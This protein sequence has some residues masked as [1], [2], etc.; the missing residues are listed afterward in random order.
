MPIRPILLLTFSV[1]FCLIPELVSQESRYMSDTIFLRGY[2]EFREDHTIQKHI[3]PSW[4]SGYGTI[5]FGEDKK[6]KRYVLNYYRQ[7]SM[8]YVNATYDD[9]G[10][11]KHIWFKIEEKDKPLIQG[12][13]TKEET[14]RNPIL[15]NY[16]IHSKDSLQ[17]GIVR[18]REKNFPKRILHWNFSDYITV[19]NLLKLWKGETIKPLPF[20]DKVKFRRTKEGDITYITANGVGVREEPNTQSKVR[21]A[22]STGYRFKIEEVM[23]MDSISPWGLHPW[24][25]VRWERPMPTEYGY[26]FGA[27]ADEVEEIVPSRKI[28]SA[29]FKTEKMFTDNA[30]PGTMV[31]YHVKTSG[32]PDGDSIRYRLRNSDGEVLKDYTIE[33]KNNIA[34]TPFF[35][36]LKEWDGKL[37]RSTTSEVFD[38]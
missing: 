38:E 35:E 6:L 13:I 5:Y 25:K 21:E 18:K 14:Q 27:F 34:E 12:S 2:L 16:Q 29:S 23:P 30:K 37:L 36:V 8:L 20:P 1:C 33:V 28:K 11:L 17:S 26:I 32:I 3:E 7:D 24:Y 10:D 31:Q 9:I 22:W 4:V 15:L 19:E